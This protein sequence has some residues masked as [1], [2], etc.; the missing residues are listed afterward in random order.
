MLTQLCDS[1]PHF[2]N[3]KTLTRWDRDFA[4]RGVDVPLPE[5]APAERR[6]HSRARSG[7]K[8]CALRM[9]DGISFSAGFEIVRP[10]SQPRFG[11][12]ADMPYAMR[13]ACPQNSG[14][15]RLPVMDSSS[16]LYTL[17]IGSPR[18]TS[19]GWPA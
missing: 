15:V 8:E 18:H 9:V 16:T 6:K 13:C 10:S 2:P 17:V 3:A 12:R 7:V 19:T 4:A 5:R 14:R 1:F 11:S